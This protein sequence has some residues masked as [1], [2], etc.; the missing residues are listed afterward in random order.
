MYRSLDIPVR[1]G[2]PRGKGITAIT[3]VGIPMGELPLILDSYHEFVDIAKIGIGTAYLEPRLTEKIACY[4]GFD[5]PVYFGG[6][7]FEK[8][9]IQDKLDDYLEFLRHQNISLIEI[10]CGTIALDPDQCIDLIKQL[11]EEFTVLVEVGKKEN[12]PSFTP[13]RWIRDTGSALDAGAQFVILE[14]RNTADAGIYNRQGALDT[15]LIHTLTAAVDQN[16]LIFEAPTS[17][18]QAQLINLLGANVNMGNIFARD[19]LLLETQRAALRE[20]T[21]FI[22]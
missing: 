15:S 10:S 12:D 5:I 11:K 21:F 2:K 1:P 4:K 13:E 9:Y 17:Q 20:E 3:D 16:R 14:G 7:L 18:S 19:L 8:Y 22:P 6:T